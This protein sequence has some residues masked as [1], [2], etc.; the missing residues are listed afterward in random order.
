[1][2]HLVNDPRV[3]I[4][5]LAVS[6]AQPLAAQTTAEE[7]D[8]VPPLFT[9]SAQ[10]DLTLR[11]PIRT[12]VS[13]A[14]RRPEVEGTVSYTEPDG[15]PVEL[16]VE[17]RTRG[18][19]RIE[20]CNFPPLSINFKRSQV[21]DTSFAEQNRLKLVT[22]CRNSDTYEQYLELEYLT[23][24]IF[25]AVT[26]YSYRARP[27]QMRYL[28]SERDDRETLAPAFLIEH[29]NGLAARNG[30]VAA[31]VP[32]VPLDALNAKAAAE[33]A[34]FQY[35][36]GNTDWSI[37]SPAEDE[38]CC[39]NSAVLGPIGFDPEALPD[40]GMIP[41]PY[42]FDQAGFI[43]TSYAAP[44]EQLGIRRVTDR[45]FRGLCRHN[46]EARAAVGTF[47]AARPRIEQVLNDDPK[48]EA[49]VRDDALAFLREGYAILEDPALLEEEVFGNCR[50]ERE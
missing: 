14:A 16:D 30:M 11:A 25:N 20:I 34:V 10:F 38:D 49:D 48:L 26:D 9:D 50:T 32:R 37:I 2:R 24:L 12:L 4:L 33:V 47:V 46:D 6:L 41:V 1:M 21:E 19:S 7:S 27:V 22:L 43:N 42:D 36:I 13:R 45:L 29:D 17:V 31:E 28:D 40:G 23:Y 3:M 8:D 15:T 44:N 18:K 35:L 5:A 39:H